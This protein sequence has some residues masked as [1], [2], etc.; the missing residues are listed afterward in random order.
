MG[1]SLEFQESLK[2]YRLAKREKQLCLVG[3]LMIDPLPRAVVL[4]KFHQHGGLWLAFTTLKITYEKFESLGR[5]EVTLVS[6]LWRCL[7]PWGLVFI[8]WYFGR[9]E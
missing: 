1:R 5:T 7:P 4:E 3:G 2:S 8:F 9:K 6:L